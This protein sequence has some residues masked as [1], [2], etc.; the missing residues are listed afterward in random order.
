MLLFYHHHDISPI[1]AHIFLSLFLFYL[2]EMSEFQ[3]SILQAKLP[4]Y[5]LDAR[6]G[7]VSAA[8]SSAAAETFDRP[9][10]QD[11]LYDTT[12][13]A[14]DEVIA[15]L[16]AGD[17]LV[18]EDG[19]PLLFSNNK[20]NDNDSQKNSSAPQTPNKSS[21]V[22]TKDPAQ[23]SISN[24]NQQQQQTKELAAWRLQIRAIFFPRAH[25][26][27]QQQA[28]KGEAV[29][30]LDQSTEWFEM[31]SLFLTVANIVVVAI[32]DPTMPESST[33]K[34][35]MDK[36]DTFFSLFYFLEMIIR[37]VSFGVWEFWS[38]AFNR[39]DAV[40]VL[41]GIASL[42]L[43]LT[44]ESLANVTFVRAL[45][46][47]RPLRTMTQFKQTRL[48]VASVIGSFRELLDVSVLFMVF[49]SVLFVLAIDPFRG[50]LRNYCIMDSYFTTFSSLPPLDENTTRDNNTIYFDAVAA[51][52]QDLA[53]AFDPHGLLTTYNSSAEW[54]EFIYN[55]SQKYQDP[56]QYVCYG[57]V[58]RL[59]GLTETHSSSC[60]DDI[61]CTM[62]EPAPGLGF[63]C[64]TGY[65]CAKTRNPEY[66]FL[67]F[68]ISL[69][70][71]D[72]VEGF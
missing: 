20:N 3:R 50:I 38:D 14:R 45:R 10:L 49:F 40:V 44:S 43:K 62:D 51:L 48:T 25:I 28:K 30:V 26:L 32:D 16:E 71:E 21:G 37:I 69:T 47:L 23:S 63:D 65:T 54:N 34:V 13:E 59:L 8:F 9:L 68:E 41:F 55:T 72:E 24:N 58:D 42:I 7:G 18:D 46:V 27:A 39:L 4:K 61:H 66:G 29:R 52:K 2:K 1:Q 33:Q 22:A 31:L 17:R 64:P 5:R 57:T 67:G 53:D 35:A 19:K 12:E 70:E 6:G 60:Q 56:M 36:F 15:Q 11:V